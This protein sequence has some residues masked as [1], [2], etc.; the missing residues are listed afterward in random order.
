MK[1]ITL[2]TLSLALLAAAGAAQAQ[3]SVTLYGAIDDGIQ[4]VNNTGGKSQIGLADSTVVSNRW[5]LKGTE[6][7]GGGL[8][9]IFQLENGFSVNTGKLGVANTIF[10]RQ[11]YVGLASDHYGTLTLG[12]QYDAVTDLVQGLTGDAWTYLFATPGDV[13]NNDN[14]ARFNNSV[15][16]LSPVFSGLQVEGT[17]SFG[18]V[19]GAPGSGQSWSAAATY[20]IGQLSLAAGYLSMRNAASATDRTEWS[21]PTSGSA[22]IDSNINRA[23]ETAASIDIAQIAAQYVWGPITGSIRYSNALY[24]P[25]GQSAFTSIQRYNV[26]SALLQY[27][28]TPALAVALDYAY[29]N[30][31][32]NEFANGSSSQSYNQVGVGAQ[33]GISKRTSFYAIGAYQHASS[34]HT[35]S[36]ASSGFDSSTQNQVIGVIGMNHKF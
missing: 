36:I 4:Y 23:F 33:Y 12:R 17:Y 7:L 10:N 19:A 21:S 16:Y 1:K 35:A 31:S 3:S 6:D 28:V 30:G 25:D 22:V 14:S 20:G 18:G 27:Q 8:K 15:K 29:V 24:R 9:A 5:G 11:A 26:G 2:S 34:G 13:D 32:G